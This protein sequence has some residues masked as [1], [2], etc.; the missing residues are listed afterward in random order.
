[1]PGRNIKVRRPV[2]TALPTG[3]KSQ[4]VPVATSIDKNMAATASHTQNGWAI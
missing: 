3:H 1:M 2:A 4:P